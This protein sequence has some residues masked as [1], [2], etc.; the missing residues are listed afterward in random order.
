MSDLGVVEAES[1]ADAERV[2]QAESGV[3]REKDAANAAVVLSDDDDSNVAATG[4]EKRKK[5]NVSS[6]L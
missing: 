3:G 5:R 2:E 6:V 1:G 4:N